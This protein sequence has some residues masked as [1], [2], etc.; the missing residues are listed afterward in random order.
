[1]QIIRV[2]LV[3]SCGRTDG[4]EKAPVEVL[5]AL[6]KIQY[7]EQGK[8]IQFDRLNL[9]EIHVDLKNIEEAEYLIF[10]NSKEAFERNSRVLFIGG[11]HSISYPIVK[12]FSKKESD[13]LLIIF[14]A[15]ADC[16]IPGKEPT[17]EE[18]LR[19]LVEEGFD[20]R[21]VILISTRNL[22]EEEIEFLKEKKITLMKMG[23]LQEDIQG[24]CDLVME[25]ARS[26]SGFYVSID[27]DAVDPAFAPGTGYLEPGGMSSRDILYF[28]KRLMLLDN[29]RGGDIVEINP[30]KD[31]NNMTVKLGAKL[32]S[33]MI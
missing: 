25:R 20:E 26:S 30:D 8:S 24:V 5:N 3:N 4:C 17:H 6:K 7:N 11:D 23:L 13:P 19:K 2:R 18:W 9:E 1:M 33:E 14:D 31:F 29:F 10:E 12:A 28:I 21:K 22:C 32:L 16:V 27:I 15:H